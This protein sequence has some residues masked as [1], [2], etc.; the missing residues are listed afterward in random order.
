MCVKFWL[1]EVFPTDREGEGGC[2]WG[3]RGRITLTNSSSYLW[4]QHKYDVIFS[5]NG[6]TCDKEDRVVY[7]RGTSRIDREGRVRVE[8]GYKG[9]SRGS[10]HI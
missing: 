9:V 2:R 5:S 1:L 4:G 10:I 7:G 8:G 3:D 6:P